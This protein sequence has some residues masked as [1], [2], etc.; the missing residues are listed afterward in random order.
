MVSILA[1][2]DHLSPLPH[3]AETSNFVVMG[4]RGKL[5]L[6]SSEMK[7]YGGR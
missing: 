4:S 6:K 1:D 3:R 5:T 7:V 2:R